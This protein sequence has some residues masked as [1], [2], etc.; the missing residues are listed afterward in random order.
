AH[1]ETAA[2]ADNICAAL[3]ADDALFS[4]R[5]PREMP[6]AWIDR[7]H[8]PRLIELYKTAARCLP[9]DKTIHPAVFP[10]RSQTRGD[11]AHLEQA[12]YF[13]FDTSTPLMSTT[14]E[15]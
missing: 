6:L 13:C 4:I 5:P 3:S 8:D 10:K 2:R 11:P 14:W 15:T 1:L 9:P 12:G 7:T